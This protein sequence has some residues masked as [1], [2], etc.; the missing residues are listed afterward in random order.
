MTSKYDIVLLYQSKRHTHRGKPESCCYIYR[1][2]M[3]NYPPIVHPAFM[4][5]HNTNIHPLSRD[6]HGELHDPPSPLRPPPIQPLCPTILRYTQAGHLCDQ[7]KNKKNLA[8]VV[9]HRCMCDRA[10]WKCLGQR[11]LISSQERA[12][13]IKTSPPLSSQASH[14]SQM[15]VLCRVVARIRRSWSTVSRG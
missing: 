6:A 10:A 5:D 13:Q 4:T 1:T 7:R 3:D 14:A 11:T 15:A 8:V 9:L 12:H 2:I